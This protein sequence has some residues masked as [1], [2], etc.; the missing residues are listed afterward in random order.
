M[1]ESSAGFAEM[2]PASKAQFCLLLIPGIWLG[3]V[4]GISL[5]EAPLKFQ[6][7]GITL[8]LGLGIGRIVFGALNKV[9]L[10]LLIALTVA[11]TLS[12]RLLGRGFRIV[13]A[14]LWII[15]LVQ[16]FYLLPILDERAGLYIAGTPPPKTHHH[17]TYGILEGLKVIVLLALFTLGYRTQK[18]A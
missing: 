6:A 11:V 3:L 17:L 18:A 8:E 16:S 4:F 9:E 7:P 13:F 1:I 2:Q 14:L 15:V 5:M 12:F 10:G